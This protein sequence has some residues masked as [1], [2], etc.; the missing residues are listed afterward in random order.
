MFQSTP[1]LWD[2]RFTHCRARFFGV[3]LFQSTPALWDGRF[4]SV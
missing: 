1:A 3:L 4:K 2:G